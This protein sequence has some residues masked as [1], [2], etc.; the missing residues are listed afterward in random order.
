MPANASVQGRRRF[1]AKPNWRCKA[2]LG[3]RGR[4]AV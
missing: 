2:R 4:W 1:D 3:R